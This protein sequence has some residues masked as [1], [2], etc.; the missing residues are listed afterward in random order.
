MR[1]DDRQLWNRVAATVERAGPA[2]EAR[3]P[4]GVAG[5]LMAR[6]R[7]EA[8]GGTAPSPAPAAPA[9]ATP[10]PRGERMRPGRTVRA[11]PPEPPRPPD[12]TALSRLRARW[13]GPAGAFDA[14]PGVGPSGDRTTG[15]ARAPASASA[16]SFTRA[17][18]D[19]PKLDSHTAKRL[20]RGRETVERRVDL[21]GLTE[22]DAHR[23]LLAFLT[24]ARA[25]GL[26]H[27]LVITGKGAAK[28][29]GEGVLKRAVPRWLGTQPFASH[30]SGIAPAARHDGG[31]G[32][33]YVRL[34]R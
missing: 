12:A 2:Q 32:A 19:A 14:T 10:K 25:D 4:V 3:T 21:H 26:R 11:A 28:R 9:R 17:R 15:G 34:K 30:V 20:S 5:E 8:R 7:A 22:A 33:L 6:M 1:R 18:P 16:P 31:E 24:G 23:R 29:G 27:V 13:A